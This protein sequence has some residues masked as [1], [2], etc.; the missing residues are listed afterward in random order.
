MRVVLLSRARVSLSFRR[1]SNLKPTA[2]PKIKKKTKLNQ[3]FNT[4]SQENTIWYWHVR[5]SRSYYVADLYGTV[6]VG[7]WSWSCEIKEISKECIKKSNLPLAVPWFNA[8][9]NER[10]VCM[11]LLSFVEHLTWR[12][13]NS[14][15]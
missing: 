13:E 4:L 14:S 8:L 11:I 6:P 10:M 1:L 5:P 3:Y 7:R 12:Y 9:P 2:E 15:T